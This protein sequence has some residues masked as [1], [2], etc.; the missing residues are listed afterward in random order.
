MKAVAAIA[1]C[2]SADLRLIKLPLV[3]VLAAAVIIV[4]GEIIRP[5]PKIKKKATNE[6]A[7]DNGTVV[8]CVINI[9]GIQLIT[10]TVMNTFMTPY[11]SVILPMIGEVIEVAMPPAKNW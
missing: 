6:T 1:S 4:L 3:S 7:I 2:W 9:V 8:K 5:L 10:I 11:L